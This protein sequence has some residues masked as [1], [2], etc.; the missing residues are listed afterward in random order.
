MIKLY[1]NKNNCIIC[2]GK[3]SRSSVYCKYC[4]HNSKDNIES[5]LK[6]SSNYFVFIR[7]I[8]NKFN[9][10]KDIREYIWS[11]YQNEIAKYCSGYRRMFPDFV[12]IVPSSTKLI[13]NSCLLCD[14]D[15]VCYENQGIAIYKN[16]TITVFLCRKC[17]NY[18]G[19]SQFGIFTNYKTFKNS[20]I[21]KDILK[22][23][24]YSPL[25]NTD[26]KNSVEVD[27]PEGKL[28]LNKDNEIY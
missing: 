6:N 20:E 17:K 27:W 7:F 14:S 2:N 13:K 18:F 22:C 8:I 21:R 11:I 19:Y 10:V 12:A 28:S 15:R 23:I 24:E 3:R 26:I 5:C 16:T 4:F 1:N 25:L 9:L